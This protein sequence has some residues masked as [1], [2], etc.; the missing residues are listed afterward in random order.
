[1]T[2]RIDYCNVVFVG[3]P[4]AVTNKLQRVLN[5]AARVVSGTVVTLVGS[6]NSHTYSHN[7]HNVFTLQ[8]SKQ[9]SYICYRIYV[10][11]ANI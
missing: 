9:L 7:V 8:H 4:K 6:F 5:V 3:A 10:I 2:S 1:M 11:D